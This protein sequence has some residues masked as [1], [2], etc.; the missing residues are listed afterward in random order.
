VITEMPTK[1][2]LEQYLSGLK[3]ER[4]REQIYADVDMHSIL[5]KTANALSATLN[6][7]LKMFSA[8][9]QAQTVDDIRKAVLIAEP[10]M[11][12]VSGMLA[13]GELLSV[14][15]AQNISDEDAIVEALESMTKAAR[16]IQSA[17][18]TKIN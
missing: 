17:S 7:Q 13:R 8:M 16:A 4:V 6:I 12:R 9:T 18:D 10:L 14:Q 5:G 3:R 15:A 2:Q 11:I 1:E